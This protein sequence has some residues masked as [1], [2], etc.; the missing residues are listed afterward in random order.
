MEFQLVYVKVDYIFE[1][2]LPYVVSNQITLD[3]PKFY[4]CKGVFTIKSMKFC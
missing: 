1:I 4:N 3:V 2:T